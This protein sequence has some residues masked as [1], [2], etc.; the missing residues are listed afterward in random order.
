PPHSCAAIC[1][2]LGPP[3]VESSGPE[4]TAITQ[5]PWSLF[6]SLDHPTCILYPRAASHVQVTMS[7]IFRF[8]SHYAIQAGVHSAMVGWNRYVFLRLK[9]PKRS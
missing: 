8:G 1:L 7:N 9:G 6:N 2:E 3:V 4:Y 5:G